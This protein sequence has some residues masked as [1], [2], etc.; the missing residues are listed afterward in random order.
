MLLGGGS[1]CQSCGCVSCVCTATCTEPHT[2]GAFEAVYTRFFEGAEA[3]NTTDGYLTATGDSDTSDPYDGMD[4][5]GPWYQRVSGGFTLGGPSSGTRFPCEV[6]VSF[7]RN[8]YT[9]GASTIPPASTALTENVVEVIVSSGA[10]VAPDGTVITP[11]DGA[12]AIAS[13]PLVAGGGD[14]SAADPRSGDGTVSYR[15]Q[16]WSVET[17]FTI[18]ATIRWNTQKRQ[19][20]LYGIVRECYDTPDPDNPDVTSCDTFCDGNPPPSVVYLTISG[21]SSITATAPWTGT[22]A[23]L[24]LINGTYAV[25]PWARQSGVCDQYLS[26]Y[27][28][29]SPCSFPLTSFGAGVNIDNGFGVFA[30]PFASTWLSGNWFYNDKCFILA[31]GC[32]LGIANVCSG[33]SGTGTIRLFELP[34][35]SG[36]YEGTF[37]WTLSP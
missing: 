34:Y 25:D 4:G 37:S 23:N 27:T 7:W 31:I 30:Q 9:L 28:N 24:S 12:V 22:V 20:V 11:E 35:G 36:F 13:V 6:R 3:G 17:I 1:S 33:E 19:H 32:K 5:S 29:P 14:Q 18:R 8:N 21:L 10:L 26:P 16:C 2:G 15:S